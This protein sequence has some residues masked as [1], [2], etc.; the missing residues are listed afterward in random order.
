MDEP[1][2]DCGG[3]KELPFQAVLTVCPQSTA[4]IRTSFIPLKHLHV[5]TLIELGE[6]SSNFFHIFPVLFTEGIDHHLFF[7]AHAQGIEKYKYE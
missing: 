7:R 6:Y 5:H 3:F 1:V 2:R 4:F